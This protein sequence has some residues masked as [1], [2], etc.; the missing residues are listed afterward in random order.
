MKKISKFLLMAAIAFGL[1][2]CNND[3]PEPQPEGNTFAVISVKLQGS[4][5]TKAATRAL[6]DDYNQVSKWAG[7]DAIDNLAVYLVDGAT[8]ST[9]L[10]SAADFDVTQDP[11]SVGNGASSLTL[12]PNK[13]IQTTPGTKNV[14]VLINAPAEIQNTLAGVGAAGFAA[15]YKDAVQTILE[16]PATTTTAADSR[17]TAAGVIARYDTKDHILMT[18]SEDCTIDIQEGVTAAQTLAPGATAAQNRASVKAERA[19]A[20]VLVTVA[21]GATLPVG[22]DGNPIGTISNLS[23]VVAQ[24]ER[25]IFL[26][27]KADWQTP[28][29]SWVPDADGD[30]NVAG[31][32]QAYNLY[33]YEGLKVD[34]QK[35]LPTVADYVAATTATDILTNGLDGV[36]LLPN[37][38]AGTDADNGY[39]KG[40]SAYVL[41]R[42]TFTPNSPMA[43]GENYV[44]GEDFYVGANGKFYASLA[45][46]QDPAKG[47]V[48]DQTAARYVAGKV[49][50]F[51]WVNPDV[52]NPTTWRFTP[53]IRNNIYHIHI[54]AFRTIGTNW[55]PLVPSN[56]NNPGRIDED[57]NVIPGDNTNPFN[58]D[59]KPD[60]FDDNGD[61]K[62]PDNPIDPEDPIA[63]QETWMSVDVTVAPWNIH[64]Y[65][66]EL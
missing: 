4:P 51:A 61:D 27:R 39:K 57:G 62:E 6:P 66:I 1:A 42:G 28:G 21:E 3:V 14:Y 63:T 41:I 24:G 35:N 44:A 54:S 60:N 46:S 20:R 12:T 9:G 5:G 33:D 25:A 48:K 29:F 16:K 36:F 30:Y 56:P 37:T 26:Q 13:A 11:T 50:Y 18:N 31:G 17:G 53:V 45:N 22:P 47:G 64:S 15:A 8:V 43:D 2:A 19:A 59:P 52:I 58:P 23:Y 38:H 10:Y 40:N 32:G 65:G 34:Y 7:N 55:N 49:L